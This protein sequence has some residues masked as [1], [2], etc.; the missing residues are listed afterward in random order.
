MHSN[1]CKIINKHL[2]NYSW[3]EV[4]LSNLTATLKTAFIVDKLENRVGLV[5]NFR[6]N[7]VKV[8]NIDKGYI[9][10]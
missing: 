5:N 9:I 7:L 3:H 2:T 1:A 4:P 10:V 8:S 6:A